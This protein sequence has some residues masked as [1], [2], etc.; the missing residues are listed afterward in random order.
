MQ[1]QKV[2]K[3]IPLVKGHYGGPADTV[4][5]LIGESRIP[6]GFYWGEDTCIDDAGFLRAR[7]STALLGTSY[8]TG[9]PA[10]ISCFKLNAV[11]F[12]VSSAGVVQK[13]SSGW[14]NISGTTT[15]GDGST[16]QIYVDYISNAST[17]TA[18]AI[19]STGNSASKFLAVTTITGA[20]A[21][22]AKALGLSAQDENRLFCYNGGYIYYSNRGAY[23]AGYSSASD[24]Q[25]F[26]LGPSCYPVIG[27]MQIAGTLY[28]IKQ[29]SSSSTILIYKKVSVNSDSEELLDLTYFSSPLGV[30]DALVNNGMDGICTLGG[31]IFMWMRGQGLGVVT[32][33]GADI[34]GDAIMAESSANTNYDAILASA[35]N[36]RIILAKPVGTTTCF[37]YNLAKGICNG[38]WNMNVCCK[39]Y[40]ESRGMFCISGQQSPQVLSAFPTDTSDTTIV[41]KLYTPAMDFDYPNNEKYLRK[42]FLDARGITGLQIYRRLTPAD[43]FSQHYWVTSST[44][45]ISNGGF[46]SDTGWTKGGTAEWIIAS[47]VATHT[48]GGGK[49]NT[50]TA[51]DSTNPT[52]TAIYRLKYTIGCSTTLAGTLTPTLGGTACTARTAV[53]TYEEYVT[54]TNTNDLLFTPTAT[55]NGYIDNVSVVLATGTVTNPERIVYVPGECRFGEIY[56]YLAG[57]PLFLVKSL[58]VEFDV[59]GLL[60]E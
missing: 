36:F 56:L 15:I 21:S 39:G 49:T 20:A 31:N 35:T 27:M 19:V 42:V 37:S 55:F 46:D 60:Y 44:D 58:G 13:D 51:T 47:G 53:G 28:V 6:T 2:V 59:G 57:S 1:E 33:N 17:E 34:I 41:P 11:Y 3:T 30:Q 29:C 8:T 23:D 50:I 14:A 24:G 52:A 18:T 26:T 9:D 54:A 10:P 43:S 4:A 45:L 5:T 32:E 16:D 12:T 7:P 40:G 48:A 38:K 22:Q 25:W